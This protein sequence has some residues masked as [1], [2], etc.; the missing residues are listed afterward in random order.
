MMRDMLTKI[1]NHGWKQIFQSSKFF[2]DPAN[3]SLLLDSEEE[4][5][6]QSAN[7]EPQ[8]QEEGNAN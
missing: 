2:S 6:E 8:I 7:A 5:G 3:H 4:S 1:A